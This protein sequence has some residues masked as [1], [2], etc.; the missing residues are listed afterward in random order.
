METLIYLL[1]ATGEAEPMIDTDKLGDYTQLINT[2]G[3]SAVI[4]AVFIVILFAV[5]IYI[6]RVNQKTNNQL[7]NQQKQLFDKLLEGM[8]ASSSNPET[9]EKKDEVISSPPKEKNIVELFLNINSGIKDILKDIYTDLDTDRTAVYV[10]HNGVYSSH[11][12]PF[13]KISC[14]CEIVKKN[15]GVTKNINAHNGLPL[16][17]FD[18]SISCLHR[19]GSMIITDTDDENDD[20]VKNSPVLVGMLKSNNIKSAVGLALYDTDSNIM[21]ILLVEFASKRDSLDDIKKLLIEKA[22]SLSPI[23]EYSGIYDDNKN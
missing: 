3:A 20:N 4:L 15:S 16:Q 6:I 14:I 5:L 2:Y 8:G 7:I 1:T 17:M 9:T 12:L 13:F 10:F 19:N 18:N 22:P 11:G 23:L 21:G